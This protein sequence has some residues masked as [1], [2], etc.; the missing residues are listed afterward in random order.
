MASPY[1]QLLRTP[2]AWP[3]SLA[4]FF[5]R[6]PLSMGGLALLLLMVELTD[7]YF[8]AGA[9][10][11]TWILVGA[12]A[13]PA[14]AML[15]DRYGQ[16]RVIG[17]QIVIYAL[18][19]CTLLVMAAMD[20]P[21]WS[22]FVVAAVSGA[23][24]PVVGAAVRARWSYVLGD[25]DLIRTAYSWESVVDEFVFVIGPPVAASVA[26]AFGGSVALALTAIVGSLGTLA[27]LAQRHTEPPPAPPAHG[28]GQV[29]I[30]YRGMP[31]VVVV[32][33]M[34]GLVFAGVEVTVVATARESGNTA[35]AGIVL[36]LWSVSSLG[37]GLLVGGLRRTPPL[38]LQLLVGSAV[39]W[40]MLTPLFFVHSLFGIGAVLLFA[41]AGVAPALIAGFALA[42]KLVP[43]SALTQALTWTSIAIGGGFALGS[44]MSGWLVDHV[45]LRAGFW[46]AIVAGFVATVSAL[47]G[48]RSLAHQYVDMKDPGDRADD[49]PPV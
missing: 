13:A 8:I 24:L 12:V 35:A 27:L 38:H 42:A 22:F 21:T 36:G 20:A 28:K 46:V 33:F 45:S 26:A 25:S 18:G 16:R 29:A 15:I 17:P 43:T 48:L 11:A 37:A 23:A 14:I 19:V 49:R 4:G 44:P 6:L 34:L 40:L 3:F 30:R 10:D 32:M 9:V 41:G 7:S 5:A 1:A 47:L 39:T 31:A 2:R